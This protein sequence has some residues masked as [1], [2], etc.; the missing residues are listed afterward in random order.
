MYLN[1]QVLN[2]LVQT[3]LEI[4]INTF[5]FTFNAY[6]AYKLLC[7]TTAS[8]QLIQR[9]IGSDIRKDQKLLKIYDYHV[10]IKK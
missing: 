9:A 3:I 5:N 8:K 2:S 10:E 4:P 6:Y 7:I 1:R